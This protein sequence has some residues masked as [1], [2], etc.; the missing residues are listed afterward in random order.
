[1]PAML[2]ATCPLGGLRY[3]NRPLLA[4]HVREDH[5]P[6]RRPQPGSHDPGAAPSPRHSEQSTAGAAA[7]AGRHARHSHQEGEATVQEHEAITSAPVQTEPAGLQTPVPNEPAL[8]DDLVHQ[9]G[10]GSFPASDPPSWWAQAT[11]S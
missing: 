6:R 1:M 2:I 10:L 9:C 5:R 8:T 3:A 7:T 11:P 4:L